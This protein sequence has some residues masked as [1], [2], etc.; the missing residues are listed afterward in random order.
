M[1]EHELCIYL[2]KCALNNQ[3]PQLLQPLNTDRL[4]HFATR[5][6]VA[7]T[8]AKPLLD[9]HLLP[10]ENQQ[11]YWAE[12]LYKNICKT[13]TFDMER[14]KIESGLEALRIWYVPLKG[15]VVNHLYPHYGMREFA[16]NDIL[17]EDGRQHEI[18]QMMYS[19]GYRSEDRSTE[20]HCTFMKEPVLNFEIHHRLFQD[21]KRLDAINDYYKNVKE[22]LIPSEKSS[23]AYRFSDDDFYVYLI[24]HAYK[25]F[26]GS[27]FGLRQ[28]ADIYLYLLKKPVNSA[29]VEQELARLD[30]LPFARLL[31]SVSLKMFSQDSEFCEE[32]LTADETALYLAAVNSGVYGTAQQYYETKMTDYLAKSGKKSKVSYFKQRIF[33][34]IEEYK[35]RNPFLYRHKLLHPWFYFYRPFHSLIVNRKQMLLEIKTVSKYKNKQ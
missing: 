25:H 5:H 16:D 6:S 4:L 1:K 32:T 3:E 12:L 35:D 27:G 2:L 34:D 30:I 24:A 29:Y 22:R 20:V 17:T 19:L 9:Y 13:T 8:I 21:E 23:F 18:A 26:T 28:F 15:I 7:V 31:Q 11:Q 10:D 14:S 33:P